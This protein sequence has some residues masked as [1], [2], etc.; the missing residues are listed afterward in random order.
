MKDG[1]TLNLRKGKL[2]LPFYFKF[3]KNPKH[4]CKTGNSIVL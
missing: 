4:G 3:L 2:M 1:N